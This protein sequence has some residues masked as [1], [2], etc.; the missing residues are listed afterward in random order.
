MPTQK[1]H[2]TTDGDDTTVETPAGNVNEDEAY[3]ELEVRPCMGLS[4]KTFG[5][6]DSLY[7]IRLNISSAWEMKGAG[8]GEYDL[9]YEDTRIGK[10]ENGEA[11]D[12][13]DWAV[14]ATEQR[15]LAGMKVEQHLEKSAGSGT[16]SFRKYLARV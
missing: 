2:G 14:L 11:S 10:I 5:L 7:A 6:E 15:A 1:D 13:F 4:R 8:M 3:M 12:A 16:E 9:Y